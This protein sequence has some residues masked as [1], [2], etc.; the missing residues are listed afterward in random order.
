MFRVLMSSD[1][2]AL[3]RQV[4]SLMSMLDKNHDGRISPEE[5]CEAMRHAHKYMV[6]GY[7]GLEPQ[8]GMALSGMATAM[9]ALNTMRSAWIVFGP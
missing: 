8:T 4:E 5:W 1:E 3:A 6:R 7:F 9:F 2:A